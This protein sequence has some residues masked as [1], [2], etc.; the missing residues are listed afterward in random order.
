[1]HPLNRSAVAACLGLA[2]LV[3]PATASHPAVP[4]TQCNADPGIDASND[5]VHCTYQHPVPDRK[6]RSAHHHR[7]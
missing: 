3:L 2:F 5:P 6:W 7:W 1:M 4:V